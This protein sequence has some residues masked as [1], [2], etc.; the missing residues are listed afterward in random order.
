M[1][2]VFFQQYVPFAIRWIKLR[3]ALVTVQKKI[4]KINQPLNISI[5]L[6]KEIL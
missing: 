6:L 4:K 3:N 1:K 5:K 2:V